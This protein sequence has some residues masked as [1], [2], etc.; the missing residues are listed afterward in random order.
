MS[1][2]KAPKG[3]KRAVEDTFSED[4]HVSAA[5][6]STSVG[7]PKSAR[8]R[9]KQPATPPVKKPKRA[10]TRKCPV[11][12]EAIPLR[13]LG[14]HADL[15]SERL[16]EIIRCIGSTEVL[17]EAEPD[18]GLTARTRRSALK[19]RQ[20]MKPGSSSTAE[21]TLE[22]TMKTLRALKRHRKQ[23]HAKLRELTRE[24]EDAPW[25]GGR[26]SGEAM[27]GDGMVC[28]VCSKFVRGDVDVV[29]AHVDSCLAY[30]KLRHEE[31]E[32][33]RGRH[34][35]GSADI[36]LDGDLHVEGDVTFG[37][38]EGVS[39]RGTG[40]DVRN[41]NDQDVDDEIDVDGEDEVLFGAPQFTEQDVLAPP[42]LAQADE[43]HSDVD[44][45]ADVDVNGDALASGG[46]SGE[47]PQREP[48]KGKTLHDLVAEGKVVRKHVEDAKRTMDAVIG[49]GD[50]ERVD[51]AVELAR[52]AGDQVALVRALESK[53]QLLESATVSSSTSLLCRICLDPYTEPT[54]STG[55]WHTC[56]REC[57]LRC[58]G[59]TK[60][61]PICKRITGAT[62]LRRVYL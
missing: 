28:P 27:E 3:K 55:C 48:K 24:D 22:E 25:W 41:R 42:E 31:E 47:G 5:S 23:R 20:H 50:T 1:I 61:C 15:E 38:M 4:E 9:G 33:A 21:G 40:F 34:G 43:A 19:A 60:L 18:D 46:T 11:C 16:D 62:D 51:L 8:A 36:D 13:L 29:E 58:L 26:N 49:V 10:E 30:E 12:D 45:E 17:G 56:C 2:R 59:S 35:R 7:A 37:V 52:R 39:F 14:K 44:T 6:S 54:V 53:V 32:A 57:W